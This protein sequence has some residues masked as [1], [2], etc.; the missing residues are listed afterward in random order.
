MIE[1][2]CH[3]GEPM[4]RQPLGN[5]YPTCDCKRERRY[6]ATCWPKKEDAVIYHQLTGKVTREVPGAWVSLYGYG[7]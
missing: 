5:W 3:C 4:K 1:M 6:W 2:H 7:P